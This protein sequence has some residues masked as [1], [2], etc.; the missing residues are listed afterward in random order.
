MTSRN[1]FTR[2]PTAPALSYARFTPPG[3]PTPDEA[4][5]EAATGAALAR[6][7]AVLARHVEQ[8]PPPQSAP[9]PGE[10]LAEIDRGDGTVLRVCWRLFEG[11]PF[12]AVGA[13]AGNGWPVKGKQTTV[14]LRELA[15]VIN[16]LVAA[17][18]KRDEAR[19]P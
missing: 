12:V 15:A 17:V 19:R 9:D 8:P 16:G 7:R 3:N 10:I 14:K 1:A 18:E 13:W 5:D 2:G 6:A 11:K 4:P